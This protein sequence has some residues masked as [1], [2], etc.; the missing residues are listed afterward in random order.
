MKSINYRYTALLIIFSCSVSLTYAQILQST[1]PLEKLHI[2]QYNNPD[3]ITDL[4]VGLW[5]TPLPVDYDDDGDTDLVV[6]CT[7]VPFGGTYLFE[8][9]SGNMSSSTIFAPPVKIGEGIQNLTF[10]EAD[11]KPRV[12]AP[13]VEFRDFRHS[14]YTN[15]EGIFNVDEIH[16]LHKRKRFSQWQYVDYE[17]D[18]DMDLI[19]GIDDW[20]GYGWD[21]AFNAKG[22]WTKDK[23]HGY[24]YLLLNE[25]GK[26]RINGKI[27][28]GGKDIDVEGNP[29]PNIADFDGDGDLDIICGEFVDRFTWF[30]NTGTREKPVYAQGRFLKNDEGPIQMDLEMMN[31]ASIDWNKDGNQDLIVGD[32]DGRVAYIENTGKVKD[33]MPVFKSPVYFKQKA[34]YVKLGALVT[35][36]SV[37]WDNDGDE[38]LIC[39]NSAGYICFLENIEGSENPKWNKPQLLKA[40][41]EIIRIQAGYNGSIQG[42]CERK[43]GYTVLSVTDWD[44][45]GLNDII[46]NSIWGKIEWY[47]NIGKKG[48]PLLTFKGGVKIDWTGKIPTKPK[49]NWWDP[50]EDELVTQWRTTPYAIDWN[51]DGL[52]DLVMLDHEGYLAWFERVKV[53]EELFLLP[54][55]RIFKEVGKGIDD[56][57]LRLNNH[58]AGGSGR[59]KI[60]FVDWDNDGDMDLLVNS[61]NIE[62][63]ENV[64]TEDSFVSYKKKGDLF[65]K[66]LAG[67]TTSPTTVDWDNDGVRDLLI[68]AEDGHLYLFK[69]NSTDDN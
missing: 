57:L 1:E 35:P 58:E 11:K 3:L 2:V 21:N 22:E 55:K 65:E 52:M 37:D 30:A 4:A 6:S 46:T 13:G 24:V 18:G 38:D 47:K 66:R 54:G 5:A 20:A 59:R 36:F 16:R 42:P 17:N 45:D 23:L 10:S 56:G 40:D 68:G 53:D 60:C 8:N 26:Y 39:G 7:D 43:W 50:K 48:S 31:P 51:K 49:W 12:L 9:T 19:V 41:G 32:E 69:N 34:D 27:Q 29:T 28:A 15:P 25:D 62:L 33:D 63:F 67:H 64:K 14:I 61:R 44:G